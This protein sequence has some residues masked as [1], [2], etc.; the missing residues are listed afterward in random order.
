MVKSLIESYKT[1]K[2]ATNVFRAQ[3]AGLGAAPAAPKP[4]QAKPLG[5]SSSVG[6]SSVVPSAAPSQAKIDK[7]RSL[8]N[9]NLK[10]GTNTT[11]ASK[12][13]VDLS[14]PGIGPG[15]QGDTGSKNTVAKSISQAV[16]DTSSYAAQSQINKPKLDTSQAAQKPT[17]DIKTPMMDKAV[18][19]KTATDNAARVAA[20]RRPVPAPVK[21]AAPGRSAAGSVNAAIG[22]ASPTDTQRRANMSITNTRDAMYGKNPTTKAASGPTPNTGASGAG[23]VPNAEVPL[24]PAPVP[25]K[26]MKGSPLDQT[27]GSRPEVSR[28]YRLNQMRQKPPAL[29]TKRDASLD[30]PS[31]KSPMARATNPNVGGAGGGNYKA[32][33][34]PSVVST[35]NPNAAGGTAP[36][37]PGTPP[38]PTLK[39]TKTAPQ[40]QTKKPGVVKKQNA[41][42]KL[43][44]KPQAA[45]TQNNMTPAQRAIIN[46]QAERDSIG[47][48]GKPTERLGLGVKTKKVTGKTAKTLKEGAMSNKQLSEMIKNIRLKNKLEEQNPKAEASAYRNK[49][50]FKPE[51]I[52]DPYN[53]GSSP[54]DYKHRMAEGMQQSTLGPDRSKKMNVYSSTKGALEKR[55]WGGNQKRKPED[56]TVESNETDLGP[57]ETGQSGE[58][59]EKIK[60]NPKDTTFSTRDSTTKNTTI[61]ER[62]EK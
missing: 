24:R 29:D 7:S 45:G 34:T 3:A 31:E 36:V 8:Q 48:D 59:T 1:L 11:T 30:S 58:K 19:V 12:P 22:G 17:T 9:A 10:P 28:D 41:P 39:P 18:A 27:Q 21:S 32:A 2:E 15:S 54:N 55:R 43:A 13:V 4:I 53:K 33:Q 50:E 57:T 49:Q 51:H 14:K 52:P 23:P 26:G 44:R 20:V 60:V 47:R 62:K 40:T 38:K 25:N 56:Y 61:K 42:V 6:T 37:K 35:G 16:S 46:R 5:G